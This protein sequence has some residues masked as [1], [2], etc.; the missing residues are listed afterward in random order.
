MLDAFRKGRKG[1]FSLDTLRRLRTDFD[2]RKKEK[3]KGDSSAAKVKNKTILG[4]RK[5]KEPCFPQKK[6]EDCQLPT[7]NGGKGCPVSTMGEIMTQ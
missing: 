4:G 3:R 2:C 6:R 1:P 5:K 7:C